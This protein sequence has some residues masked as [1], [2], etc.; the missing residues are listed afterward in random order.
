[1]PKVSEALRAFLSARKT[2]A[3][4]DLIDRWGVQMETQVNVA[5]GD[6]EPVGGKRT[7]WSNGTE[8]VQHP[9][10]ARTPT[11]SRRGRTTISP[12]PSPSTP[13]ASA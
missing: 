5:A 4:A 9:H 3:N 10:P 2:L 13:R 12:S 11:R 7:T 8:V 1:M 6:G